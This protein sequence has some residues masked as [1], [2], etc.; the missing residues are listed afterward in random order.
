MSMK[1]WIAFIVLA[2]AL[3]ASRA[4][5]YAED[6]QEWTA[7]DDPD[8][9][10]QV[11]DDKGLDGKD[12]ADYYRPDGAMGYYNKTFGTTVVRKWV[13]ADDGEICTYIY[14]KPDKLVE[15]FRLEKLAVDPNLIRM[16]ISERGY[17]VQARLTSAPMPEL[18]DAVNKTAGPIP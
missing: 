10:K 11:L 7:M 1:I 9:L 18:V 14:V 2:V 17:S 3:T 12:F 4:S 15:C 5:V 8:A 16:T 13:I 6:S